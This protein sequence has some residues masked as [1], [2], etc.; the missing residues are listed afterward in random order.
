MCYCA[1]S[2]QLFLWSSRYTPAWLDVPPSLCTRSWEIL[3]CAFVCFER[4]PYHRQRP[5]A[6]SSCSCSF[7]HVLTWCVVCR[8]SHCTVLYLHYPIADSTAAVLLML[9]ADVLFLVLRPGLVACCSRLEWDG[10]VRDERR[11]GAVPV[12]RAGHQHVAG[13]GGGEPTLHRCA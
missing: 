7:G 2:G 10:M 11:S 5:V 3:F 12:D 1:S 6:L 13:E 9:P 4:V 8:S